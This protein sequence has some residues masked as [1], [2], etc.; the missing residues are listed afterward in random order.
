MKKDTNG[1][2][3]SFGNQTI[4]S[5]I[6]KV[7]KTPVFVFDADQ[8]RKNYR[9]FV[10][11][12][13]SSYPISVYYSVKTNNEYQILKI[14][15]DEGANVQVTGGLDQYICEKVGFK[16]QQMLLDGPCRDEKELFASYKKKIYSYNADSF[17]DL[18]KVNEMGKKLKRVLP[19]G[20][21]VHLDSH[22]SLFKSIEFLLEKFGVSG[23]EA[24]EL[25]PKIKELKYISFIGLHA[26]VGSQISTPNELIRGIR[27]LTKLAAEFKEK[28][29]G[30]EYLD[31]GGGIPSVS[32][33][34][35][36]PLQMMFESMLGI[37]LPR[38]ATKLQ[39]YGQLVSKAIK[40]SLQKHN[41]MGVKVIFEPG[42]AIVSNAGIVISKV[43]SVKPKWIFIDA[44]ISFIPENV[45]FTERK[46]KVVNSNKEYHRFSVAGSSLL[47]PD[48]FAKDKL[49]PKLEVNDHVVIEDCGAYTMS[50]SSQFL[51]MRPAIYMM[52]KGKLKLI[53]REDSYE[54]FTGP[55]VY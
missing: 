15:K 3:K 2:I 5:I 50:R 35:N 23:S 40:D 4:D 34:R 8:V 7:K 33:K 13:S 36:S 21:R 22:V 1:V 26:H 30:L 55:M 49:L 52:Q 42:R 32:V 14:L 27:M 9:S 46:L 6:K 51:V 53:R 12:F 25:I 31:F 44:S 16:S 38:K 39:T 19:A 37:T 24:I 47:T 29:V 54:T 41:L 28:G 17:D 45:F 10:K 43:I 11:D 48:F 18:L 20:L